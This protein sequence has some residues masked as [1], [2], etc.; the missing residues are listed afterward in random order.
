MH[1]QASPEDILCEGSLFKITLRNANSKGNFCST[2]FNLYASFASMIF[3]DGIS[4]NYYED[5]NVADSSTHNPILQASVL[6]SG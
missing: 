6:G 1:A 3:L 4:Y 2:T 5:C